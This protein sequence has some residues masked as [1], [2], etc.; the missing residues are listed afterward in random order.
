M[1]KAFQAALVA[2]DFEQAKAMAA[3][4]QLMPPVKGANPDRFG[5]LREA[6]LGN[7][8]NAIAFLE[9]F[10]NRGYE[11]D[12]PPE[13]LELAEGVIRGDASLVRAGL[14][15]VSTR[16][17]TV[18]TLK[19]Y[20]TP[21]KLRRFGSWEKMLPKI[22]EH[23][24]GFG[25]LMAD[26]AIAWMSLAWHRGMEDAFSQPELF[27]EWAPWELCCPKPSLSPTKPARVRPRLS[28]RATEFRE[29]LFA[30]ASAG[31][32]EAI[33]EL[34]AQGAR[35]DAY[36]QDRL[37]ALLL[38]AKGNHVSA[39]IALIKAG[40]DVTKLDPKGKTILGIAAEE[41]MRELVEAVLSSGVHPD[42]TDKPVTP[43]VRASRRGDLEIMRLL[44]KAGA[45]PN[46]ISAYGNSSALVDAVQFGHWDAACLLIGAGADVNKPLPQSDGLCSLHVAARRGDPSFVRLLLEA[47]A[48]VN[49]A[50]KR[51]W[52][53]LHAAA[54]AGQHQVIQ[55]L[56]AAG[57][58]LDAQTTIG[59][60]AGETPLM[61]AVEPCG[62][63]ECVKVLLEAGADISIRNK[64]KQ[65]V[66]DLAQ[67]HPAC[68]KVLSE[69][70]H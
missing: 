42:L 2:W 5:I 60:P 66:F 63:P 19:T 59:F 68:L 6:I 46:R 12:F 13:L 41:G 16:F 70:A 36:N 3:A 32:A 44:L 51:G 10:T 39:V 65:T 20:R 57:A 4:Y 50:G 26:W 56:I 27:C 35:L 8:K 9:N 34:A 45:D 38:A 52:T 33:K 69:F 43:L 48:N 15:A 23:L 40:A 11:K 24:I 14:K 7:D 25:W 64:K 31:D 1:V 29:N 47:G 58:S 61:A 62:S 22:H 37:T 54:A 28:S 49:V 30:V 53:P 17:K 55:S 21:E 18:W 67:K